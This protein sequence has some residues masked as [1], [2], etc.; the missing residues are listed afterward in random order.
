MATLVN[1]RTH[2]IAQLAAIARQTSPQPPQDA[3]VVAELV[4]T[5]VASGATRELAGLV[6]G[7]QDIVEHLSLQLGGAFLRMASCC[8]VWAAVAAV[9]RENWSRMRLTIK[10]VLQPLELG[11]GETLCPVEGVIAHPSGA[12]YKSSSI[13]VEVLAGSTPGLPPAST[14]LNIA[15]DELKPRMP[16]ANFEQIL[17]VAGLAICDDGDLFVVHMA[18]ELLKYTEGDLVGSV[19]S[20][21]DRSDR[22]FHPHSVAAVGSRLYVTDMRNDRLVVVAKDTLTWMGTTAEEGVSL[23]LPQGI[24]SDGDQLA[25]ADF[26]NDRVVVLTLEGKLVRAIGSGGDQPGQMRFPSGVAMAHNLIYVCDMAKV[27]IQV[28]T[29]EGGLLQVIGAPIRGQICSLTIDQT[30][31]FDVCGHGNIASHL[32]AGTRRDGVLMFSY[33]G[34]ADEEGSDEEG[35]EDDEGSS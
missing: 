21:A 19:S 24:A 23:R 27:R 30:P 10:A 33:A 31:R 9:R 20:N 25:V 14:L 6:M 17:S 28:F 1:D 12:V 34:E 22:F 29:Q 8:T 32:Y 35:E 11:A 15:E 16:P 13:G 18:G 4:A 3:T 2:T 7:N 26:G 5:V